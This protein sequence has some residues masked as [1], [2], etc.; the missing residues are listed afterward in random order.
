M[1]FNASS[2]KSENLHFGVLLLS[3]AYKISAKKSRGINSHNT[4]KIFKL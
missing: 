4:E 3:T 2:G 1:N